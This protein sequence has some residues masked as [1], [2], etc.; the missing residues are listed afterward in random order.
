MT[1][2]ADF[3]PKWPGEGLPVAGD[4]EAAD[5]GSA[6]AGV[7]EVTSVIDEG[8]DPVSA[9]VSAGAAGVPGI[10]AADAPAGPPFVAAAMFD[11]AVAASAGVAA[12]GVAPAEVVE[13]T[14][15]EP[16]AAGLG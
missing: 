9:A 7:G 1:G 4:S 6:E 2:V 13:L 12:A 3:T 16:D 11:G 15:G 8:F 10:A 14:T 5:L